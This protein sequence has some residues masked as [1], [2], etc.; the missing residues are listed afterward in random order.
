MTTFANVIV[1]VSPLA[2]VIRIADS[3]EVAGSIQ[4]SSA[5]SVSRICLRFGRSFNFACA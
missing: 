1:F 4:R 5:V 3:S 2:N